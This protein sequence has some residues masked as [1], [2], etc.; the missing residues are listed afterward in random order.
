M[1]ALIIFIRTLEPI[2]LAFVSIRTLEAFIDFESIVVLLFSLDS[3]YL[4]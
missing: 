3:F 4:S 2:V 1:L